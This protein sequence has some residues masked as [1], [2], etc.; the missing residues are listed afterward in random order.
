VISVHLFA[1]SNVTPS[2][3]YPLTEIPAQSVEKIKQNPQMK[4][5]VMGA[6]KSGSKTAL[7]KLVDHPAVS[8]VLAAI[9]GASNPSSAK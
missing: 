3:S 6:L 9:E 4:E 7:E 2:E 1:G 5:R 8:I